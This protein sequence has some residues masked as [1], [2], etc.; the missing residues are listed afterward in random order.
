MPKKRTEDVVINLDNFAI[1]LA[2]IIAGLLIAVGIFFSNKGKN[3]DQ[4]TKGATVTETTDTTDEFPAGTTTIDDDPYLGDKEKVKVAIVEFSDFQCGYCKRHAQEVLPLIKKKYIDTGKV[5]YVFRDFQF[6]EGLSID[7]GMGGQ[8]LYELTKSNDKFAEYHT[9]I[10][11]LKSKDDIYALAKKLGVNESSFKKCM[12]DKRYS[13]E[14]SKDLKDG[15]SV[16]ISGTPGF[17]VGVLKENGTVEGKLIKGAYP[18]ESFDKI[19]EEMLA[20]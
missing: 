19:I 16:G 4:N 15:Q 20:K 7:A 11:G 12:N 5:I 2:I 13:D 6:F 9:Q 17:V 18:I 8:C 14:L 10:F 1:P 3:T